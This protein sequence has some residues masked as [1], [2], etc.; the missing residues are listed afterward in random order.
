[1]KPSVD[2]ATLIILTP[3]MTLSDTGSPA[4]ELHYSYTDVTIYVSHHGTSRQHDLIQMLGSN[5]T[6]KHTSTA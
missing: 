2:L 4:A 1:M 6:P 3:H 5:S